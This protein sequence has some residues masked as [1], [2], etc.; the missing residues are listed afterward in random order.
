MTKALEIVQRSPGGEGDEEVL[1]AKEVQILALEAE[2]AALQEK[3]D[4]LLEEVGQVEGTES[5]L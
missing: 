1:K 2:N 5:I 3:V 4:E